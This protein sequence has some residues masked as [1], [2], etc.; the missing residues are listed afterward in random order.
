MTLRKFVIGQA[1]DFNGRLPLMSRPAGP[2]E[3]VSLL[4]V[5]EGDSPTYRAKSQAEPFA[6]AAKETDL[7]AI[8]L[9]PGK[10]AAAAW[11]DSQRW[12]P[13]P[14]RSR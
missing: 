8:G 9:P 12:L 3:I 11:A 4:P 6:R 13:P 2:F 10:Q 5:G 1:V 7:V 14:F